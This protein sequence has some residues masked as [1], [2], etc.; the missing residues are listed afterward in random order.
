MKTISE[1]IQMRIFDLLEGNL[2]ESEKVALIK[3]IEASPALQREYKLLSKT[4]LNE[5]DEI[6]AFEHK[7]QLY[8]RGGM[9]V[10]W[11]TMFRNIAASA[12]L[13]ACGAAAWY[14]LKTEKAQA[15]NVNIVKTQNTTTKDS[16]KTVDQTPNERPLNKSNGQVLIGARHKQVETPAQSQKIQQP[17]SEPLPHPSHLPEFDSV[18]NAIVDNDQLMDS[19]MAEVAVVQKVPVSSSKKRS[20]SYK[21]INGSKAML[22]NLQLPE[23]HLRT[24]KRT[25]KTIPSVKMEIR[26]YKTDVI[27]TLID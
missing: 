15:P 20:L 14:F 10:S 11:R 18:P 2:K 26:T 17:K 5:E 13:L 23:V 1:E 27:A 21:L 9:M 22:A 12:A 4:Y 19:S 3:E 25:N 7:E 16:D 8:R 24:E 6:I